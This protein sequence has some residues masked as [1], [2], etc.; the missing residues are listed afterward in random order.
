[1][2]EKLLTAT[3]QLKIDNAIKRFNNYDV[4]G[5]VDAR[6]GL[7]DGC[8]KCNPD[9]LLVSE[10]LYGEEPLVQ[11]LLKIKKVFSNI[12]IV[13]LA[14]HVDMKDEIRVN[15]MSLLVLAEIYDIIDERKMTG[16]M[17]KEA[18]D[19][20]KEERDVEKYVKH[21][22]RKIKKA[23]KDSYVEF[24]VQDEPTEEEDINQDIIKNLYVISSIKPGTGKS[25]LSVNIATAIAQYGENNKNG[26]RPKVALIEADLQNLSIGT[27]LQIEDPKRNIKTAMDKISTIMSPEGIYIGDERSYREVENYILKSFMP[28]YKCKNLEALVG[29]QLGINELSG[30]TPYHYPY[31]LQMIAPHFDVIIV[32][33]NSAL[34]HVTSRPILHMA[35][36]CYFIVNLDFNNVRNNTRYRGTLKDIGVL[37]KVKYVLNEDIKS[38]KSG[39]LGTDE[40]ALM[41]TSKHLEDSGFKLEAKIPVIPKTVFLN[42]L[43]EGTPIVLDDRKNTREVWYELLKVANQIYPIKKFDEMEENMIEP[44]NKKKKGLFR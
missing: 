3:G 10:G 20:P 17:L 30:I 25:F 42:R 12:R 6:E 19:N 43:F 21:A 15:E 22:E 33:T 24:D 32:D 38:D 13:Y 14:G 31:L 27:L 7:L 4:V 44:N 35:K 5:I 34:T 9:I 16:Q 40:E 36:A 29:S 1:M 28:F 39:F 8:E 11:V 41:F 37:N 23:S 18:L 2:R 26:Q